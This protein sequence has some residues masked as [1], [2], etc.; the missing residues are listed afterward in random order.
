MYGMPP[1][2]FFPFPGMQVPPQFHQGI[3]MLREKLQPAYHK[4][5]TMPMT[6][7]NLSNQ[8]FGAEKQL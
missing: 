6:P 1:A 2:P 4:Q 3:P 7:N 8:V 5:F